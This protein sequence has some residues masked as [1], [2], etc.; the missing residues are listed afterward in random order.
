MSMQTGFSKNWNT[1]RASSWA[2]I[3]ES[4]TSGANVRTGDSKGREGEDEQFDG[5]IPF[6]PSA[7]RACHLGIVSDGAR[8]GCYYSPLSGVVDNVQ[9]LALAEADLVGV[10]RRGVVCAARQ[11]RPSSVVD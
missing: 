6:V 3:Y 9:H 7:F 8:D 10:V 11:S 4:T 1:C 5:M 2:T